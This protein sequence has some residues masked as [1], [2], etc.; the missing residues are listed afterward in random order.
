MAWSLRTLKVLSMKHGKKMDIFFWPNTFNA[1]KFP[2]G[3]K[4][5][6]LLGDISTFWQRHGP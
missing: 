5:R 2:E 1:Q 3:W 4:S 6:F